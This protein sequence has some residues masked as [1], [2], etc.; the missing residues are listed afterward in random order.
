MVL[1]TRRPCIRSTVLSDIDDTAIGRIAADLVTER[2]RIFVSDERKRNA[3]VVAD[4]LGRLD[5]PAEDI[6][7]FG[8]RDIAGILTS[9]LSDLRLRSTP[10]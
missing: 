5:K 9:L 1:Y 10:E 4:R 2:P 6:Y 8:E 3:R 7:S